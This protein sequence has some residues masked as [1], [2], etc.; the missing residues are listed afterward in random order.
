MVFELETRNN[1][2][3]EYGCTSS[4]V[5]KTRFLHDIDEA[6]RFVG[7]GEIRNRAVFVEDVKK[8]RKKTFLI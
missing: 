7:S 1:E 6:M 5:G 8:R 4:A 2:Q 3:G